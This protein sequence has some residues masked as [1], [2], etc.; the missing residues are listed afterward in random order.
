MK[1][2]VIIGGGFGGVNLAKQLSNKERF[3]VTLVDKNNYNF[4]PPLMYQIATGFLEVSNIC[5]PF[6]KLFR[7]KKNIRF[8]MGEF[9]ELIA[10]ENKVILSTGELQYDHLV[11][12]TGVYTNYFGMENVKRNALPMKN[13]SDAIVLRNHILQ[14]LEIASVTKDYAERDR[15]LTV[16]IAGGG[17]TGV[18]IS[19]M[20]ADLRKFVFSKEYHEISGKGL[21]ARIILVDGMDV[22]L[23]P[24]SDKSHA[25]VLLALTEMGIDIRLNMQV[26]DYVDNTVIFANGDEIATATLIW[27]AGVTGGEFKGIPAGAYD[28]GKRLSVNEFNCIKGFS[29][30]YAIGDT[31]IQKHEVSFPG[32]HPQLAQVAIQQ[33]TNLGKNLLAVE[34]GQPMKP[35]KYWDKGSMAIIGRNKAVVDLPNKMH[36]RGFIAWMMWLFVHLMSLVTQRNRVTTFYNWLIAWFT[37]DQALR[38]IIRPEEKP[39]SKL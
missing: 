31:C 17:P 4:F 2:I 9:V 28:R 33:G 8:H 6:R 7:N 1:H 23:K 13:V 25:D 35:F 15:L 39:V 34:K 10:S 16:V 29:N 27:A 5:Y 12:A 19:G 3:A 30:V 36:F 18:E 14:M 32:G 24:M 37:K 22:L 26:K 38:M 11:F 21:E 20:L